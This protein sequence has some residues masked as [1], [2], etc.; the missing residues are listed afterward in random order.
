M[1][2]IRFPKKV[3]VMPAS[4]SR[5]INCSVISTH[6]SPPLYFR[7]VLFLKAWR[8]QMYLLYNP[9]SC[10]V[11]YSRGE[12]QPILFFAWQLHRLL[13]ECLLVS[14]PNSLN[15]ALRRISARLPPLCWFLKARCSVGCLFFFHHLET[16]STGKEEKESG[17]G[18]KMVWCHAG[19]FI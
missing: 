11:C 6:P 1:I 13:V 14:L 15:K 9:L 8:K 5:I 4:W 16:P 18:K 7:Y 12:Q 3:M 2:H 10:T 17:K 19:G